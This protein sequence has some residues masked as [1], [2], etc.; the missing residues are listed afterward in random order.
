[1]LKGKTV[2]ITG[3]SRG[4]GAAIA[5]RAHQEGAKVILHGQSESKEL[6]GLAD[7]LGVSFAVFDVANEAAVARTVAELGEI[8]AL[9]NNAGINPS[10]TFLQ[11]TGAAWKQIFE[12]NFFGPIYLSLAVLP[13]MIERRSGS[14]VNVASIKAFP[15]VAG[16]PAYA[17]SKAALIRLTTSM[18]DEFAQHGI[19][20]NAVAPGF[21]GTEMTKATLD[22]E[23]A[24]GKTTL[25]DQITKIPMKRMATTEEIA[26]AVLFLA[27]DRASYITGQCLAVDGG[28]SI[29]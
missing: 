26:E 15:Y 25:R 11:L 12:T 4:I 9:I 20:V 6:V 16:K 5:K 1:M 14:I 21:T 29:V 18:A 27:S 10:R 2:L 7:E 13:G 3:S 17:S 8:D 19:R 23:E 28:L 24:A 22:K